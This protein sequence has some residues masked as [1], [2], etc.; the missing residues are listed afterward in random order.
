MPYKNPEDK[1]QWEREHREQ[2]N[3]RRRM[4]LAATRSSPILP[5]PALAP[6]SSENPKSTWQVLKRIGGFALAVG[7]VVLAAL[8][9]INVPVPGGAG[10]PLAPQ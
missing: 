9:G 3:A 7:I 1:R 5:K 6:I 10:R 4:R 2:R 8:S